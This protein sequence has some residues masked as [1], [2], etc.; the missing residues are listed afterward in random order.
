MKNAIKNYWALIIPVTILII[1]GI[2]M[3]RTL[4][5]EPEKAESEIIGMVDGE[6][7][8][9]SSSIP[10]RIE[11][12]LVNTGDT[13]QKD[14]VLAVLESDKIET[15]KSQV[16][17]AVIIT[18]SQQNK[19]DKG[20]TPEVLA[21]AKNVEAIA[22]Q[23]MNLMNKTYTRFQNL[24]NEGVISGQE[25]DLVQFKYQ[26]AKK[27]LEIARMN[28]EMLE[29]GNSTDAKNASR[30]LA[31]QA[32]KADKLVSQIQEGTRLKAP[33]SGTLTNVIAK[34]GEMVNA[35]YPIMSLLKEN[36]YFIS[37]NLR[38][39][40]I[41]SL[42]TG[43][44]VQVEV[45]GCNPERFSAV[46]SEVAPALGYANWVPEKQSGQIEMRTFQVKVRPENPAAVK[47]L[48]AGMTARLI[49]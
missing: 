11:E 24:Y 49:R 20:V 44:K 13:I 48:R 18:Q 1:A 19:V 7:I 37:F 43:T 31:D 22:R 5:S 30:A 38:Q 16:Q 4:S 8:D 40:L 29:K 10:G 46:V 17:D 12:L 41:T 23:Q 36:S 47:G 33:V 27:E 14:Q 3:L 26:A 25:R 2:Y 9:I 39:E 32:K 45:P 42:Q 34:P 15:L 35:G 28:V 6:F 21:S